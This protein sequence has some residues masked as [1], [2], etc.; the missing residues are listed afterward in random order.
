[1]VH[2]HNQKSSEYRRM[3]TWAFMRDKLINM[4]KFLFIN[5]LIVCAVLSS[6]PIFFATSQPT[7]C[8]G[9]C[10]GSYL[11]RSEAIG[12]TIANTNRAPVADNE[13]YPTNEDT[14]L[15]VAA[16]DGL[17]SGDSD[18]DGDSLNWK[19]FPV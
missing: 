18:P 11:S 12:I 9:D 4:K 5:L 7:H 8:E 1:M 16:A 17:L 15:S 6:A 3:L 13:T 10:G 19:L 14:N 2:N